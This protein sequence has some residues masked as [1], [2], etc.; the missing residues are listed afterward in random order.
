[1][2]AVTRLVTFVDIDGQA[3]DDTVAMS[4]R[5]EAELA[6]GSRVLL[7]ND[8]GWG[9]FGPTD[10]WARTSVEDIVATT[11]VVV[12]PDEPFGDRS[13]ADMEA[14]HWAWL[15]QIANRQGVVTDAAELRQ[16]PHDVLLSPRLLARMDGGPLG[17]SATAG[18][19]A[20]AGAADP[21][22]P[23]PAGTSVPP[24]DAVPGIAPPG[25]DETAV[26]LDSAAE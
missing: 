1:M 8:R 2:I 26:Y 6:D 10:I 16:L 13:Q 12:G 15:Q 21:R 7:L 23:E 18:A 9:G 20:P 25:A 17:M 22:G 11:R 24:E 5:H 19:S 3:A 14:D 4:A